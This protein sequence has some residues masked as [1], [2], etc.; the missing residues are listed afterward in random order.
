MSIEFIPAIYNPFVF[1]VRELLKIT[2]AFDLETEIPNSQP[3]A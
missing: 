3:I 1:D 2:E